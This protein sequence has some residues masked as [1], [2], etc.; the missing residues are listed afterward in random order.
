MQDRKSPKQDSSSNDEQKS[1]SSVYVCVRAFHRF[2][3]Q[4][5]APTLRKEFSERCPL[6]KPIVL[7]NLGRFGLSWKIATTKNFRSI[8]VYIPSLDPT[9]EKRSIYQLVGNTLNLLGGSKASKATLLLQP[10]YP[11]LGMRVKS[12]GNSIKSNKYK[13]PPPLA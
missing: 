5:I 12:T 4:M 10:A 8:K 2:S 13:W 1:E 7:F 6:F 11:A 3:M 9:L